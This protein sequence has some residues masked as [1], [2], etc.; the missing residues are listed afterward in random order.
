MKF[1]YNYKNDFGV[2]A[3][4]GTRLIRLKS[5]KM[6]KYEFPKTVWEVIMER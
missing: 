3:D 1:R 2:D 6:R 4:W 5:A